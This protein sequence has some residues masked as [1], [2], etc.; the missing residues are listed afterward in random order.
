[1][2]EDDTFFAHCKYLDDGFPEFSVRFI[3]SSGNRTFSPEWGQDG[4]SGRNRSKRPGCNCAGPEQ[5]RHYLHRVAIVASKWSEGGAKR[6][7]ANLR[8]EALRRG[9]EQGTRPVNGIQPGRA[10]L[11]GERVD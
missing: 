5:V 1:M 8:S 11:R 6:G 2:E 4:L 7:A 3:T 10:V 9:T